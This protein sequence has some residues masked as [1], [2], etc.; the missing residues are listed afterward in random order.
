MQSGNRV[1]TFERTLLVALG[2]AVGVLL[3]Q[4]VPNSG[5]EQDA[6]AAMSPV[7][8]LPPLAA[9]DPVEDADLFARSAPLEAAKVV[10]RVHHGG[11]PAICM[12]S[13]D[14]SARC[15]GEDGWGELSPPT[16]VRFD[17]L[18]IGYEVSCG[19]D[20]DGVL[21]CWGREEATI[22]TP[23]GYAAT[24]LVQEFMV[25]ALRNDG[26]V[27]CFDRTYA[28][29]TAQGWRLDL[30]RFVLA[31]ASPNGIVCGVTNAG[32]T[33]CASAY[34]SSEPLFGGFDAPTGVPLVDVA[35]GSESACGLDQSGDAHCWGRSGPI[36]RDIPTGPFFDLS[37]NGSNACALTAAGSA[38]C[39][40]VDSGDMTPDGLVMRSVALDANFNSLLCGVTD[41]R[42][43]ACWP[44]TEDGP[45]SDGIT[46]LLQA[47]MSQL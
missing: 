2:V 1:R 29:W 42:G 15:A 18:L 30:P 40:G 36:T 32:A 45:V 12:I 14:G 47:L 43:V 33:A 8:P 24:L 4:L 46:E 26:V 38:I 5:S 23:G 41:D 37:V 20:R 9:E 34:Q 44:F 11:S 6:P 16:E 28:D 39:W 21:R 7:S 10:V 17:D 13:T 3:G 27:A 35:V 31:A 19:V 22:E 25:C